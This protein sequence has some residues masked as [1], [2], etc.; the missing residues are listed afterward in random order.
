MAIN[1]FLHSLLPIPILGFAAYSGTG[2]TTLLLKLLPILQARGVRVGVI[3]HAHH[4]FEID[5]QGKDSFRLRK[6]GG[7]QQVLL[8]SRQRWALMSET[9]T[10]NEPN[11]ADLLLHLDVRTLDLVL[12]EGFKHEAFAK[13]ELHRAELQHP[14]LF[15]QDSNIVAFASDILPSV[16]LS[17]PFLPLSDTVQI[18]DFIVQ[19]CQLSILD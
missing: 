7:A 10:Q 16:P 15:T 3:K 5:H 11:L 2:K 19:F 17:M 18:A 1:T 13:I 8:A 12:I 4:A 6:E 9:P 14:Y